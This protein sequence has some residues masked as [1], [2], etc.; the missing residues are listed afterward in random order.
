MIYL[1]KF[2]LPGE[3]AEYGVIMRE[4]RTCFASLYPFGLFARKGLDAIS[5]D[6]ITMLYGGN[7]S[8]KSRSEEHT[9]ELQSR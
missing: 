1:K 6:G 4:N 7:G 9:S 8:G 2:N 3:D 5:F